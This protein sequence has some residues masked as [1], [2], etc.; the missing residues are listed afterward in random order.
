MEEGET[1]RPAMAS[2]EFVAGGGRRLTPPLALR[3]ARRRHGV[4]PESV[5]A[6]SSKPLFL[7]GWSGWVY[8]S[9]ARARRREGRIEEG[10]LPD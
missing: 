4:R 6:S 10:V 9:D 8:G 2:P 5:S 1:R 7:P 3:G